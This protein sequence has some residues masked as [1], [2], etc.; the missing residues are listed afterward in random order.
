MHLIIFLIPETIRGR[1]CCCVLVPEEGRER[2]RLIKFSI[3]N[4]LQELLWKGRSRREKS[5]TRTSRRFCPCE[6]NGTRKSRAT[7]KPAICVVPIRS[8]SAPFVSDNYELFP[9]VQFPFPSPIW[10][11]FRQLTNPSHPRLSISFPVP[12]L[13]GICI[14]LKSLTSAQIHLCNSVA[15]GLDFYIFHA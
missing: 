9:D 6:K 11:C 3:C 13:T 12:N 10:Y 2:E 14:I 1:A 5:P 7:F 4:S 15:P 8:R